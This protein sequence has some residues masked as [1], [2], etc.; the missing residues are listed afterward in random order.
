MLLQQVLYNIEC[1]VELDSSQEK[2][3]DVRVIPEIK[4]DSF[5]YMIYVYVYFDKYIESIAD[6][7]FLDRYQTTVPVVYYKITF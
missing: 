3:W 2:N 6:W 1:F 7:Q 4:D 5:D